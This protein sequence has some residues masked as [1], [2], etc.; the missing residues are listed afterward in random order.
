MAIAEQ[1]LSDLKRVMWL[2]RFLFD[3]DVNE[4]L[5]ELEQHCR[6]LL[7]LMMESISRGDQ[8]PEQAAEERLW[9][10]DEQ[11]VRDLNQ[12]FERYLRLS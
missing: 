5:A 7:L 8:L 9:L 6:K 11:R 2:A 1:A 12:R 3:R 4:Y 10:S